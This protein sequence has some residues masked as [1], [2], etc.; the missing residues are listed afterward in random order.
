M[1]Q[2]TEETRSG[3]HVLAVRGRADS[4]TADEL[5]ATLRGTAQVVSIMRPFQGIGAGPGII[6]NA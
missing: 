1:M 3:W 4:N 2:V 6:Y 5:E